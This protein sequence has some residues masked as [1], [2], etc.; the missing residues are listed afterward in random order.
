MA[1]LTTLESKAEAFDKAFAESAEHRGVIG[2]AEGPT[3]WTVEAVNRYSPADHT[4]L[5]NSYRLCIAEMQNRAGESEVRAAMACHQE[6]CGDCPGCTFA[7]E[8]HG[9]DE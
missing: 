3:W 8:V 9:G 2:G 4:K 6:P 1:E 5:L 7:A